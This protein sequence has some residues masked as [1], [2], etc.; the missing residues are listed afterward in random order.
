[1]PRIPDEPVERVKR[2]V[3]PERIWPES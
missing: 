1:M 2:E 3:S